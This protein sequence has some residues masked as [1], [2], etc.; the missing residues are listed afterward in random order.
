MAA[1]GQVLIGFGRLVRRFWLRCGLART[2]LRLA[3]GEIG[4]ECLGEAL[5]AI[6]RFGGFF[7][8]LRLISGM[9]AGCQGAACDDGLIAA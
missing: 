2:A 9:F 5:G 1:K 8:H 4:F 6:G 3:A 7:G